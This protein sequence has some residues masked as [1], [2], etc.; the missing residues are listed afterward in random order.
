MKKTIISVLLAALS[1]GA[2]TILYNGTPKNLSLKDLTK[3]VRT[4]P[5]ED[6]TENNDAL[7][8]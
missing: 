4:T 3:K 6:K 8:I 1:A 7:F 2:I 5:K